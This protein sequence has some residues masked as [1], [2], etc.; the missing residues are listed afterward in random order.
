[1]VHTKVIS[2]YDYNIISHN[3]QKQI[4]S[5]TYNS[6]NFDRLKNMSGGRISILFPSNDLQES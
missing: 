5:Q 1:M 6:F 2:L 3:K 4:I